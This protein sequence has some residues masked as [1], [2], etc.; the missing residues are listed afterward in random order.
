MKYNMENSSFKNIRKLIKHSPL[1]FEVHT[2]DDNVYRI[3]IR[4]RI[5]N[6]RIN[7]LVDC[8]R[9]D[10]KNDEW[11]QVLVPKKECENEQE[12]LVSA[13]SWINEGN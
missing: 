5:N 13:L 2:V 10:Q 3:K 9:L 1:L 6:G 8:E 12:C 7:Y 11:L 4:E